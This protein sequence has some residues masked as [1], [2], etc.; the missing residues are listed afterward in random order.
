VVFTHGFVMRALLWLQQHSAD[1]ITGTEMADFYDFQ[2]SVSMP[3]CA[4]LRGSPNGIGR[5]QLSSN[6][7]VAHIPVELRTG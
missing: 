6:A 3:N 1:Q 4:V 5:F 7:S 2:R